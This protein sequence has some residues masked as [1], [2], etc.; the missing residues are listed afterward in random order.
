M[1]STLPTLPPEIAN[2]MLQLAQDEDEEGY[3]HDREYDNLLCAASLVCSSWRA[4]AQALL[5]ARISL[6]DEKIAQLLLSSPAWGQYTTKAWMFR[7]N[8]A[9]RNAQLKAFNIKAPLLRKSVERIV[10]GVPR[11]LNYLSLRSF[12]HRDHLSRSVLFSPNL[13]GMC[14]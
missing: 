9:S 14:G 6:D 12:D 7:G 13:A 1:S 11:G 3:Y 4:E 5:W 8:M 2:L 10:G